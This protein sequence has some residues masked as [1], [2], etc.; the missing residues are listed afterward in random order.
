[1]LVCRAELDAVNILGSMQP[2][3]LDAHLLSEDYLQVGLSYA[4]SS[5]MWLA[6]ELVAS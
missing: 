5:R 3:V 1:M 6:E 2:Q 4:F